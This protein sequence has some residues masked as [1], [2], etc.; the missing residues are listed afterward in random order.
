MTL[1]KDHAE[2]YAV[3]YQCP[4]PEAS[5]SGIAYCRHDI[6]CAYKA[7]FELALKL[8]RE[9]TAKGFHDVPANACARWLESQVK[10]DKDFENECR[11]AEKCL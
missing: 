3:P 10:D 1:L 6:T 2:A 5:H 7:G 8:L 11:K 4:V 9:P